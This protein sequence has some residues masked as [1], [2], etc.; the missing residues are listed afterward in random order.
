MTWE[1][2]FSLAADSLVPRHTAGT[3]QGSVSHPSIAH[4]RLHGVVR[5]ATFGRVWLRS[6]L[7]LLQAIRLEPQD[8]LR[9]T[10]LTIDKVRPARF[11]AHGPDVVPDAATS[12]SP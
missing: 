4:H 1:F 3:L 7:A 8:A 12:K 11:I 9:A 6:L 10:V 5:H 2:C